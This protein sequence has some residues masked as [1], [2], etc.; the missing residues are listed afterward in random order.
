MSIGYMFDDIIIYIFK[1]KAVN[2][3]MEVIDSY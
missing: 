3:L 1:N 2:Q